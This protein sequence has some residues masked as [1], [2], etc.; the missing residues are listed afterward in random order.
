MKTA[1]G[2]TVLV[3]GGAIVRSA[4]ALGV[5]PSMVPCLTASAVGLLMGLGYSMVQ[6]RTLDAIAVA[7]VAFVVFVFGDVT[8]PYFYP[9]GVGLLLGLT[10]G[11]CAHCVFERSQGASS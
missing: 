8:T 2:H 1:T 6:G 5:R 9:F 11:P 7:V 4:C 10:F 3:D